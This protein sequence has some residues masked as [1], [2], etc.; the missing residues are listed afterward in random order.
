MMKKIAY[1]SGL[2]VLV[3]ILMVS[4]CGTDSSSRVRTEDSLRQQSSVSSSAVSVYTTPEQKSFDESVKR[5][6]ATD[7]DLDGLIDEDERT[8]KTSST[9]PD[10]DG[11]GLLDGDEVKKT[12][13]D[14]LKAD[15][16]GDGMKDG[17]ELVRGRNPLKKDASIQ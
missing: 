5:I 16:D 10:T 17:L 8:Y 1:E 12:K 9:S 15:T 2:L 11:D 13:T 4:G 6:Y 14:P 7:G 3:V